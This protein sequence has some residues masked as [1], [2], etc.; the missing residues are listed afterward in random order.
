MIINNS[1]LSFLTTGFKAS[2]QQGFKGVAPMWQRVASLIPSTTK[3]N[4]YAWL[5][6]FPMLREWIGERQYQSVMESGYELANKKFEATIKVK[7]DDIE[8]D[9]YG[10]YGSLFTE[11]GRAAATHPDVEIF[12]AILAGESSVCFDG[13]YFF[14]TDHPV[15]IEGQTPIVTVSN[16]QG[17]SGPRWYLLDTTRALKP[18]IYQKRSE[19]EF[20]AKFDPQTSDVVFDLDEYIYGIRGRM[21]AGYGFWQMAA[22]SAQPVTAANVEALYTGM[23]QLQSNEGRKLGIQPNV[24]LCGPSTYFTARALI[25]AQMINA[26]SN[27]LYKLVEIVN[28]PYLD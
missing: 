17:G 13:Q 22:R 1:N 11:Y 9:Q 16:N 21:A 10:V 23:T 25:E 3:T 6:Q 7:R 8:D 4:A 24:L 14:D 26:T 27:T 5:G 12:A 18:F 2:Y 28:V 20:T 15:G 19:Y